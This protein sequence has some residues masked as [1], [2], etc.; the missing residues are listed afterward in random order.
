MAIRIPIITDLQ[1]KGLKEAQRQFGK[2]KADIAAADGAMGKFKAGS[3][4]AFDSVKAHAATFA[5][6]AAVALG[7]FALKGAKAFTDLALA[8]GKFAEATGLTTQQASRFMEVAGDL[9]IETNVLEKSI[10][11]MNVQASKSP[12]LFD[13]FGV[14][15]AKTAN[16]AVN[17]NETFLNVI[18][19]LN[20][21]KDPAE[22]ARVATQLLGKGWQDMAELVGQGS[23]KLRESL[24][25]VSDQKVI[26]PEE[27][28][29]AREFRGAMDDLKD[30]FE[31]FAISLGEG[32]LPLLIDFLE[33]AT[34]I[35]DLI[36]AE[37]VLRGAKNIVS[38]A[39]EVKGASQEVVDLEASINRTD[40]A[41]QNFLG[42]L[43]L[44]VAFDNLTQKIDGVFEA[45]LKAFSGDKNGLYQYNADLAAA[46]KQIFDIATQIGA[47]NDQ[48]NTLKILVD[49]RQLEA[50][51][52]Y[53]NA[54][55]KGLT[56]KE[57]AVSLGPGFAPRAMGGP[58]AGGSTYLVGERGPELFTPGASGSITPNHA[59][60]GGGG[61]GITV[62]VNGGD[63][64]SIVRALQQYVR[65]SGPV[66]LNTRTM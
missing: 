26:D 58:V 21:I 62:N 54:I 41:W 6:G 59:L 50:A 30:K 53:L 42:D 47:T 14:E 35:I 24:K 8:A 65:Q 36:S 9:G 23:D 48:K 10:N 37:D 39:N 16:G 44:T 46:A 45:A 1:D 33:L 17:A 61:G 29:R 4:A 66:P 64:N 25:N 5:I 11:K 32:I 18:D 27:V 31:D 60:G 15:I 34:D 28:A 38:W 55:T 57:L 12:K 52:S 40:E 22:R 2:F 51:A 19:R 56:G 63:P 7:T 43:D 13:E 20:K 49:T 3:K